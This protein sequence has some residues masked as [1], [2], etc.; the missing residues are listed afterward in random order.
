M[1][2]ATGPYL[3]FLP[4]H[5]A[6]KHVVLA[7]IDR[8]DGPEA[9]V[10][11]SLA[12][13]P[14]ATMLAAALNGVVLQKATAERRLAAV[15]E[16]MSEPVHRAVRD[17]LS[18]LG[19]A[20]EDP[21]APR[22]ARQLPTAGGGGVLLF[23][24]THCPG[25]CEECGQC[26]DDCVDC[27]E[28][29]DDGCETCLP[30][31]LTPRTA[32]VLSHSLSLLADEI[33]DQIYRSRGRGGW[34]AGPLGAVLPCFAGQDEWFLRRYARAF[35]DLN[36]DL[37]VGRHPTPTCTAEEVAL[38]LAIQDAERIHQDEVELVTDLEAELPGSRYDYDWDT[39]QE[40]LFQDKDYEGF[41]SDPTPL[42]HHE[43]ELWFEAFGNVRPRERWRGFRR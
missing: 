11:A 28:C 3:A 27:P 42:P 15:L 26:R 22:V 16:G 4:Q 9:E 6:T 30:V 14:P 35:D 23:P 32:A 36:A 20:R 5:A 34:E 13:A 2:A 8:G 19:A 37:E 33:Y 31:P 7:V 18:V 41:L 39:L 17:V 1:S 21:A 24:T 29:A 43:A 12:D 25:R 38:D 10:L 40:V